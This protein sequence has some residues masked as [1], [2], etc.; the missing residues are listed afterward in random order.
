M[1]RAAKLCLLAA[2]FAVCGAAALF[3]TTLERRWQYTPPAE[4]YSVVS[5][6]LAA[7][8]A[9]D[10]SAAYRQA[11]VSFQERFNIETFSALARTEYP[12][13]VR[14]LRVEFGAV[15]FEGRRATVPVYFFLPEGETIP[16]FYHLIRE[17]DA[18]KI[19]ST[20]VL[21]RWPPNR[22]LGGMRA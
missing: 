16:C 13:L 15:H 12:G 17:E 20:R 10:Y 9:D 7:F 22:R 4:L 6:Q 19:D 1:S 8:R 2:L 18:W 5:K 11:S 14:A 21:K 3:Q